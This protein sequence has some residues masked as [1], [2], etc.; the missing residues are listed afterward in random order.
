MVDEADVRRV[1]LGLPETTERLSYGTPAW[2][3]GKLLFAR[4]RDTG[5]LMVRVEDEAEKAAL[6]QQDPA[7]FFTTPHYDGYAAILARPTEL[8]ADRL[9]EL[10][11]DAWRT[12]ATP[13]IRRR[14]PDV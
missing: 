13:A 7:V 1:A 12:R 6:L 14:H 4:V 3:V 10:L 5:D 2:F 11:T 8:A 9:V